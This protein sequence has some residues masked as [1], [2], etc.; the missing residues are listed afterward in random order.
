M[1]FFFVLEFFI[2]SIIFA[3]TEAFIGMSH[4]HFLRKVCVAAFLI[5]LPLIVSAQRMTPGRPSIEA[6]YDVGNVLK[7][8]PEKPMGIYL[9]L[10]NYNFHGFSSISL[11]IYNHKSGWVDE[12][13]YYD[14]VLIAPAEGRFFDTYDVQLGLGYYYRLLSTRNRFFIASIGANA[15]LGF[16][17]CKEMGTVEKARKEDGTVTY[18]GTVG[19]LLS[20]FPELKFE[21]FPFTNVSLTLFGRPRIQCINGLAA[22]DH[23][24]RWTCGAGLKYYL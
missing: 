3:E 24:L 10:C 18:Y 15:A 8:Y 9:A 13:I 20:V 14:G 17:Y 22:S 4:I 7:D 11:D 1:F 21:I 16:A 5:F 6:A 19:F 12:A 2:T 23:W